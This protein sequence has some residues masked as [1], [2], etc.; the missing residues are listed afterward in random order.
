[1][2]SLGIIFMKI[3]LNLS[4]DDLYKLYDINKI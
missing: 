1:M 4:D 3:Y 2:F